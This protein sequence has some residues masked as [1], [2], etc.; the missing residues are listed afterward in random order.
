MQAE[1]AP[2]LAVALVAA[3]AVSGLATHLA[4]RSERIAAVK[5][6]SGAEITAAQ[7]LK[8]AQRAK[9]QLDKL[10][11]ELDELDDQIAR[12]ADAVVEADTD[13]DRAAAKARLEQ[14]LQ[15]Q[16]DLT[17]RTVAPRALVFRPERLKYQYLVVPRQCIENPLA[18]ECS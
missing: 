8:D 12:A 10:V 4:P 6:A 9:E 15:E 5:D 3:I 13:A 1:R 17:M 7:A 14:L 18:K 2:F 11:R 16:H